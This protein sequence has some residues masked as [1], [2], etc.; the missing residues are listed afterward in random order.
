MKEYKWTYIAKFYDGR[1]ERGSVQ[2]TSGWNAKQKILASNE[3]IEMVEVKLAKKV[4]L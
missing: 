4:V 2:A 3:L 1:V